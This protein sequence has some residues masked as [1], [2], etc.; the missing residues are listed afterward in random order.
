[1]SGTA[2]GLEPNDTYTFC[3]VAT[4]VLGEQAQGNEVSVLTGHQAPMI[5]GASVTNIT[6]T[7]AMLNAEIYPHGEV[8]TY[9]VEYGPSNAYGSST[10]EASISAQHGPANIQARLTGLTGNSEYHYRII[11]TNGTGSKQ[12]P[13]ETFTTGE[14]LAAGSNS[15]PDDRVFEMITPPENEDANVYVPQAIEES[16]SEGIFTRKLF[17]VATDGSAVAYE[18]DATS[19]GGNGEGGKGVGNQFLAKR[20]ATGGWVTNSIQ[21]AGLFVDP[22]QGF[23]SD[24]S[25]GVLQF[26]HG[27]RTRK[28][29]LSGEALGGGY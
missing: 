13:D 5:T 2:L 27:S 23:S 7:S 15:L 11:A 10:P 22:Y 1:M 3:L 26:G 16:L 6:A 29:P 8:T 20:R 28:R 21:P 14:T 18:G 25:V 9:R 12:S 24:L 19:G 17:Q 4:N